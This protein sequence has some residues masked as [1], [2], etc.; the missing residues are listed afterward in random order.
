MIHF[1]GLKAVGESYRLPLS[2]YSTN[3]SGTL[4]LLQTMAAHGCK[5]IVFSSSATV[6]GQPQ[7][8]PVGEDAP[9][10]A[11]NPYGRTKLY[12]EHILRDLCASDASWRVMLL[13]YFN[14][15]G[16]HPSGL[17]GEDPAGVPNNL[18]PFIQQVAVGRRD[19][20]TVFGNDYPTRDGTGVSWGG[21]GGEYACMYGC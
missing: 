12:V 8:V 5:Q 19:A 6:Y 1:A 16:A 7:S 21:G 15:V 10:Q 9:L 2:Y 3:I 4:T 20:L 17:I 11:L 13:R 18:M 14:P